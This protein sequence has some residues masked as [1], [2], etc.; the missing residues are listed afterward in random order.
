VFNKSNLLQLLFLML[1]VL[2]HL[3]LETA[4]GLLVSAI[5]SVV[6]LNTGN[7]GTESEILPAQKM[8]L[9]TFAGSHWSQ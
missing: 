1:F 9:P 2:H 4:M 6:L 3:G 7:K 8:P 5:F